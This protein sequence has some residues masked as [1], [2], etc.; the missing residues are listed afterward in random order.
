MRPRY[1]RAG[2]QSSR[3][4]PG[5]ES[6]FGAA[7]HQQLQA[8]LVDT[9][10]GIPPT[11]LLIYRRRFELRI[12]WDRF[13]CALAEGE[14]IGFHAR[15]EKRD[16]EQSISDGLW[17]PDQLIQPLFAQ[18]A[19]ALVVNVTSVSRARR[20]SI[21]EHAKPH[22]RSS[23]RR[24][25][26]QMQI[27]GMKAVGD[28]PA[29]RVQRCGLPP[30]RPITRK[31]PLIEPQPR[32]GSIPAT[33]V[34]YRTT[35]RGKVL[36]TLIAEVVLGRPQ[37]APIGGSFNTTGIDRNQ[38]VIDALDSGFGQQLLNNHFRLFVVALAE[39]MMSN[40]PLRIDEIQRRPIVVVESTPDRIVAID[41]DRILDS[42][43]LGGA[44][45]VLDVSLECEL[46]RVDAD[47]H[48]SVLLVF[49][50]PGADIRQ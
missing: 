36:G 24:S 48:Q 19:V 43:V 7:A 39:L 21:D 5:P 40:L 18:R 47:H 23:R 20:Q 11:N 49:L 15:I 26:D 29:G 38:F 17:L 3:H 8:A 46:R 37:A 12:A 44:A 41:R 9:T 31:R 28:P 16:L 1:S 22:G 27:A 32:G 35:G 25:H 14:R 30:Y 34:Q 33:R 50:G 2:R 45:N 10:S 6:Y 42:H 4:T 13:G